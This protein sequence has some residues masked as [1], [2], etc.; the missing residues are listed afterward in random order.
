LHGVSGVGPPLTPRDK[1]AAWKAK[2]A[3]TLKRKE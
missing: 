2:R 1:K 3:A